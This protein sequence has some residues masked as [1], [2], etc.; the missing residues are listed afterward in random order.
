MKK[1][2]FVQ[3]SD[4]GFVSIY[5][6][7]ENNEKLRLIGQLNFIQLALYTSLEHIFTSLC[8]ISVAY[9]LGFRRSVR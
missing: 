8:A 2:V 4:S 7:I 5:T 6:S 9:K 3:P 1:S